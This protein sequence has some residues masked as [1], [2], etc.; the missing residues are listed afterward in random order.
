MNLVRGVSVL[1]VP[2]LALIEATL[3]MSQDAP[4]ADSVLR[5]TAITAGA[6]HTC[7]LT[8]EGAAYCWGRNLFGQ[9]GDGTGRDHR[10]PI[11]VAGEDGFRRLHTF[12]SHTCAQT[13]RGE[14]RCWGA[15][16]MGQVG[17]GSGGPRLAPVPVGGASRG[18]QGNGSWVAKWCATM[19]FVSVWE[20][21]FVPYT[22]KARWR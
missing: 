18:P 1:V 8:A 13:A 19:R 6:G 12:G 17:G 10:A 11:R 21:S 9:L 14:V 3:G 5:F 15:D 22:T 16:G 4:P 7:G 20:G 2:L